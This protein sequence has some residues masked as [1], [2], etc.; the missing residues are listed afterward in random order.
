MITQPLIIEQTYKAPLERVWKSITDNEE[1]KKWYFDIPDFKAVPGFEFEFESGPDETR[2]YLH[3]C[4]ITEV[5]PG[6]KLA[7]TWRYEGY[8]GNTLVTFELF[9]EAAKTRLKLTHEGLH[10]FP[11]DNPDFSRES[12]TEGWNWIIGTVLKLHVEK[13]LSQ[14]SHTSYNF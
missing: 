3:K 11:Q 8:E 12:F 5:A 9:D 10:T 7:Y 13:A 14:Q 6:Q 1:M 2:Q 4:K